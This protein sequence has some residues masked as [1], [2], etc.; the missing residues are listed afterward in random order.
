MAITVRLGTILAVTAIAAA[1]LRQGSFGEV[2]GGLSI[3]M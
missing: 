2:E 3:V 1:I